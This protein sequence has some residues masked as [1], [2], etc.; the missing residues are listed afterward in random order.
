MDKL[1]WVFVVKV[2]N[3]NDKNR[4]M[5]TMC[6]NHTGI[7]G[8]SVIMCDYTMMTGAGWMDILCQKHLLSQNCHSYVSERDVFFTTD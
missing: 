4:E 2:L 3:I 5:V 6:C 7:L 8:K 1:E